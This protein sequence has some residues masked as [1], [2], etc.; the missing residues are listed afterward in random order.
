MPGECVDFGGFRISETAHNG[1]LLLIGIQILWGTGMG[2]P[3]IENIHFS[4]V[5]SLYNLQNVS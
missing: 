5:K 1:V 4:R 3:L 2:T